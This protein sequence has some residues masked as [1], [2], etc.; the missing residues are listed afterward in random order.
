VG[1][2]II[3]GKVSTTYDDNGKV[4]KGN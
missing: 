3:D 1:I 4:V 2:K